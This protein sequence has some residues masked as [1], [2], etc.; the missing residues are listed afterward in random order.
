MGNM[1]RFE[2]ARLIGARSLQI[3]MGAPLFIK[4]DKKLLESIRYDPIK[5]A[6]LEFREGVIPLIVKRK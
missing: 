4:V 1:S 6:E 5:L 2:Y 3:A